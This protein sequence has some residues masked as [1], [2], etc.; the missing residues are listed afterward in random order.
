ML[1]MKTIYTFIL[2]FE[3]MI[4]IYWLSTWLFRTRALS[5]K[6]YEFLAPLLDPLENISKK[7]ALYMPIIELSPILLLVILVYLQQIIIDLF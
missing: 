5:R 7:S 2:F 1:I 6:L 3:I 4:I